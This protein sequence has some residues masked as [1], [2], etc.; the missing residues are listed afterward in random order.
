MEGKH[1]CQSSPFGGASEEDYYC[2]QDMGLSQKD[3]TDITN[4]WKDSMNRS[5]TAI[6]NSGGFAWQLFYDIGGINTPPRNEC[7]NWMRTIGMD[8]INYPFWY[9]YTD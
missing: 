8:L 2:I 1:W 3:V 4:G 9:K 5:L 6:I 7:I